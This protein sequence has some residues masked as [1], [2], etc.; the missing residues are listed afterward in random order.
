MRKIVVLGEKNVRSFSV[1]SSKGNQLKWEKD[2]IWYKAD[3]MGYEGLAEYMVSKLLQY[4]NLTEKDYILYDTEEISY[5]TNIYHGCKSFDFL[6]CGWQLITLERLFHTM[7]GKSLYQSI[8]QIAGIEERAIFLTEQVEQMT[9]LKNFGSYLTKLLTIDALFLN[10]DRHMHN[11]AVL[12][13]T[14]GCY[15]YCPIFDNGS[16][17]LSDMTM[18]YPLGND[19]LDLIPHAEAKTLCSDFDEQLEIVERLYGQT[20]HFFY[21]EKNITE[22]LEN[23]KNYSTEIKERV[24]EILLQQRRKY[25]NLF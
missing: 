19:V 18:D 14:S 2:G 3:Y 12:C 23:E 13:D 21:N 4:S 15:H 1:Q 17:L 9:G 5:K 25:A 16:A 11:I 22:V 7:Y 8:Y 6:P 24:K 20:I 10:E